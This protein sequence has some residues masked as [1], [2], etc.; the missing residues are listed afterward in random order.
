MNMHEG[1][2]IIRDQKK[3]PYYEVISK[4]CLADL[5]DC[6]KECINIKGKFQNGDTKEQLIRKVAQVIER[7]IKKKYIDVNVGKVGYFI[8]IEELAKEIVEFLGVR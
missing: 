6:T 1:I 4:K 7:N 5:E 3:C 8:R 2:M